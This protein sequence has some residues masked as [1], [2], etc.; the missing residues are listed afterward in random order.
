MGLSQ[1]PS[2]AGRCP[3]H[4]RLAA[5]PL[6]VLT[7]PLALLLRLLS[8]VL[9]TLLLLWLLLLLLLRPASLP[10]ATSRAAVS[11]ARRVLHLEHGHKWHCIRAHSMPLLSRQ[12]G[13]V[14][15]SGSMLWHV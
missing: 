8:P 11:A 9:S 12:G 10:P 15:R 7:A 5:P 14:D 2:Q 13:G 4:L 1:S 6:V 3:S